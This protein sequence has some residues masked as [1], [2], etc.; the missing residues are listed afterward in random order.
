MISEGYNIY[1]GARSLN[2]DWPTDLEPMSDPKIFS[3]I[4]RFNMKLNVVLSP[5]LPLPT[6]LANSG[7]AVMLTLLWTASLRQPI[8]LFSKSSSLT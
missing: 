8:H 4:G 6:S 1:Y 5:N 3:F 2:H 7:K